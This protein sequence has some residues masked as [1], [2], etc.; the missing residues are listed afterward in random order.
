MGCSRPAPLL[1]RPRGCRLSVSPKRIDGLQPLD[2]EWDIEEPETF[3]YPQSGSMGCSTAR[4]C[5]S[6]TG[7][8]GLSVSPKRIDG[9]QLRGTIR[10]PRTMSK[11]FSIPKAD[12]WAA[13]GQKKQ[14]A[15][16]DEA[17]NFQY[18]QSGSMGCS[19]SSRSALTRYSTTFSIPKADRWAAALASL[20]QG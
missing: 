19:R 8:R 5:S 12:R 18:P 14:N 7:R 10:T 4:C 15:G 1:A 2:E 13:A 16:D 20:R 11:S 9:L 17:K 6:R 3:Q